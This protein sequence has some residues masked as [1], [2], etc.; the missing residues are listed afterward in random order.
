MHNLVVY[1]HLLD[2]EP[3][4]RKT[5][6][7]SLLRNAW[8][9]LQM[10]FLRPIPDAPVELQWNDQHI[11]STTAKDG[12]IK[13]EWVSGQTVPA[14]WHE[15]KVLHRQNGHTITGKGELF[16]PHITQYAFISDID[17]TILISHSSTKWKRLKALLGS[18]ARTR[19]VFDDV[20]EHYSLLAA[21]GTTP[22]APNPFFYVSS[23]E[24]NLYDFLTAFFHFNGLPKGAL[25]LNHI[26]RWWQLLQTGKTKHQGKLLR[27]LRILEAFPN[28][29]FVLFGDNTQSDPEIYYT[30][31][32]RY[33]QRI[34]AVYIRKVIEAKAAAAGALLA[35]LEAQYGVATCLFAH[36]AEAMEHSKKIGLIANV[37]LEV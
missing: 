24:W 35:E 12:F 10:F 23:S 25:L 18:N 34:H 13:F 15:V 3:A 20:V 16:V 19:Q 33:P 36:S 1:G 37:G 14:G 26:K 8:H 9:L 4:S 30:I 21:S 2:K 17:D 29:R 31:A 28:Q 11:P 6:A 27:I 5:Y 22:D 7:N 32:K